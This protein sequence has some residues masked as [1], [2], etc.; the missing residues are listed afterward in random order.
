[1]QKEPCL[2]AGREKNQGPKML[3]RACQRA[4]PPLGRASAH[5]LFY[6]D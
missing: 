5:R 1:M 2:P 4:T 6:K 3:P